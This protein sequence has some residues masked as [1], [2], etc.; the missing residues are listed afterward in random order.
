MKNHFEVIFGVL[1]DMLIITLIITAGIGS[2]IYLG[3]TQFETEI[4]FEQITESENVRLSGLCD[5]MGMYVTAPEVDFIN[6]VN[7]YVY[8]VEDQEIIGYF[9]DGELFADPFE[10][11]A[12]DIN[13][14]TSDVCS[15]TLQMD[16]LTQIV[17]RIR[18]F[19]E[20]AFGTH[21]IVID[22]ANEVGE[23]HCCIAPVCFQ[24]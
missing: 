3:C 23:V 9:H 6:V 14:D 22:T 5:T 4:E 18:Y 1:S 2:A 19:E 10:I 20:Y 15:T 11:I 7:G 8:R 21:Y 16:S 13:A 17:G 12:E 24:Q